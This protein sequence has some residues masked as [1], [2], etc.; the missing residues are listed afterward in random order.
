METMRPVSITTDKN[1]VPLE[2][3]L[4]IRNSE[5]M[6]GRLKVCLVLPIKNGLGAIDGHGEVEIAD[7]PELPEQIAMGPEF[8][9]EMN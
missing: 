7:L 6:P 9:L 5:A 3:V 1:G 2:G 4:T 8:R